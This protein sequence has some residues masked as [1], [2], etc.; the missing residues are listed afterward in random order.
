MKNLITLSM[1]HQKTSAKLKKVLLALAVFILDSSAIYAQE[2][3]YVY[4]A[5]STTD[6][7]KEYNRYLPEIHKN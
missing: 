2:K 5:A 4:A 3:I 6:V 1:F 7:V